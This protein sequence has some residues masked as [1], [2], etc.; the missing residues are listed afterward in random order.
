MARIFTGALTMQQ[1]VSCVST[2]QTKSIAM[3][4]NEKS[5]SRIQSTSLN[6]KLIMTKFRHQNKKMTMKVTIVILMTTLL[7][8]ELIKIT[9]TKCNS[10]SIKLLKLK[11]SNDIKIIPKDDK[12][13]QL[14]YLL[15]YSDPSGMAGCLS[16]GRSG[17]TDQ[18]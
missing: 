8:D 3:C 11:K 1:M 6:L 17:T 5:K 10:L 18:N 9:K 7:Y 2:T 13:E 12:S 14:P 16:H 15:L 4:S